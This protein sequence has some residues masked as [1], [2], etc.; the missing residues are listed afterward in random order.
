MGTINCRKCLTVAALL[1][2]PAAL[3]L[4]EDWPQWRGPNRDGI[5][6]ETGLLKQWP[7]EGPK[8][9]W[10]VHDLGSGY[11]TPSVSGGRIY[12][13]SNKG[14]E[15][16][17][18][19]ALDAK[20]GRKIWSTRIGKVGN[21]DQNPNF[22]G[23]RSTPTVDGALLYALG[24]DGDLVCLETATGK[25][26]WRKSLRN[27]FGGVP[28]TWA[29]SESP[30]IDGDVV[31]CTPGGTEATIVALNKRTGA[32]I[33]KSAVPGGG[34]AGYASLVVATAGSF[35]QYIAYTANGLVGVDAR[36]GEFLWNY[37]KTKGPL[38]MSM[39]TPVARDGLIYSAAGRVGGGAVRLT[40][41]G[42]GVKAEEVYFNPG[43][44][45]A[46]GGEVLVGEYLYGTSQT[47][48]MAV[49]FR[50][51]KVA[52]SDRSVAPASVCYADGMLYLHG[53]GGEVALVEATPEAYR[54]RGRFAPPNQPK[55]SNPMEKSWAYPVISGGR[56]YIRDLDN[57]WCYDVKGQ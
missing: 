52:W 49:E 12:L 41:A 53:E 29:Y 47:A 5:S 25:T 24:S 45:S 6:K 26:R 21:P 8:L 31:A 55:H 33:W 11:A 57:L 27:D 14:L 18:V 42:G 46:I 54:E 48:L 17:F 38:G 20:D 35:K 30:L 39:Q 32:L 15:D 22:P 43:L 44:P 10:Q 36:T 51:G 56:L 50:T 4:T 2:F 1:F 34:M 28:G 40:A 13:L 23:A 9:L 3:A 16:E 37:D 19:S 7:Q